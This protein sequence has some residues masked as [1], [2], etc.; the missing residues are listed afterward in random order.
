VF[1]FS[2]NHAILFANKLV[3]RKARELMVKLLFYPTEQLPPIWKWQVLSFQRAIWSEGFVGENRLRDWI[4]K[5]DDHPVSFILV[6][7]DILIGHV[8]VVWKVIEHA[9]TTFKAYGLTGVFTYPAFRGQGYGLQ[10]VQHAT[11]YIDA[12]DADIALFN[13]DNNVI[14]FYQR[15]GWETFPQTQTCI[16]SREEPIR[17]DEMLM[18]RFISSKGQRFRPSFEQGQLFFGSD[19]TW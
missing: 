16:G 18:M 13:C 6:E 1:Y 10:L 3:K 4:T 14:A 15:A 17:V 12:Q 19:S 11:G 2:P 8:N 7:R 5:S 9:E